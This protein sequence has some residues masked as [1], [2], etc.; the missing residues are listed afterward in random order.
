VACC[1][2]LVKRIVADHRVV[3][4]ETV[5]EV[6]HLKLTQTLNHCLI[7]ESPTPTVR[8]QSREVIVLYNM[9]KITIRL[10]TKLPGD[11]PLSHVIVKCGEPQGAEEALDA[12]IDN[13]L[14]V[15]ELLHFLWH[16]TAEE[17]H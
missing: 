14:A 13:F 15:P 7:L 4:Y 1:L 6:F 12:A 16:R 11:G 5:L 9:N 3:D 17:E 8:K 2:L 10:L